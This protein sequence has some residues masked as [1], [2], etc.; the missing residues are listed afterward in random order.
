M[1]SSRGTARSRTVYVLQ[2]EG[3]PYPLRE[4][5]P[6]TSPFRTQEGPPSSLNQ[7]GPPPSSLDQGAPNSPVSQDR[8]PPTSPLCEIDSVTLHHMDCAMIHLEKCSSFVD[9]DIL[10]ELAS[11]SEC[12][13]VV[14]FDY[15][16]WP[17]NSSEEETSASFLS[18][19]HANGGPL[20]EEEGGPPGDRTLPPFLPNDPLLLSGAQWE[21]LDTAGVQARQAWRASKGKRATHMSCSSSSSSNSSRNSNSNRDYH[22]SSNSSSNEQQQQLLQL[23]TAT[24]VALAEA[25]ATAPTD[26]NGTNTSSSSNSSS[27]STA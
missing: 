9:P 4:G 14:D 24:R 20:S 26:S 17:L 18:P 21:L 2:Q 12:V 8:G 27:S 11:S 5:A 25:A 23:A 16:A 7:G 6:H 10:V 15:K 22:S 3:P 19:V 13:D 1:Q